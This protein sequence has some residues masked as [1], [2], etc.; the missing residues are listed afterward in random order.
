[1]N[2]NGENQIE[3]K[4]LVKSTCEQC[5][6]SFIAPEDAYAGHCE[7]CEQKYGSHLL[8]AATDPFDYAIGL[9]DGMVLRWTGG[10]CTIRGDWV[11]IPQPDQEPGKF[12]PFPFERGLQ[13]RLSEIAWVA[14]APNGS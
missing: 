2:N 14:D 8:K 11:H 12:L 1:M 3:E 10:T 9:R 7:A 13:V 4:K 6:N 5:G